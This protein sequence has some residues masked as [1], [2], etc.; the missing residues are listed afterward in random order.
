MKQFI[1]VVSASVMALCVTAQQK[2]AVKAVDP[3]KP[4]PAAPAFLKTSLDS[5]SYALGL[6]IANNLK[7]QSIEKVNKAAMQKAMDD[8]FAKK[9]VL[10]SDQQANSVIQ[11]VLQSSSTKKSSA[12]KAKG[13]QFLAANKKRPGVITLPSGLQYEVITKGDQ[14]SATP[15]LQDTVVAHYA[16]TLTNG[17]EFDNSYKRGEPLTIPVAGVIR[18]W[19]EALQLMHIGDK[20]KVYIPSELGYG[21]RGAGADIPG[22]AALV[23]EMELLGIKPAGVAPVEAPKEAIQEAPKEEKKN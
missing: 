3:S 21:D 15:Q 5:F 16:G 20:W 22:G 11:T 14:A 1:L 19:T 12:E 2:K 9:A 7:Q 10:L 17:K 4:K 13:A 8:V 23:F 18:G 6:N